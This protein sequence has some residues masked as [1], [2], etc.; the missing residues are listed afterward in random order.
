M[1][2]DTINRLKNKYGN[3]VGQILDYADEKE[4][5]LAKYRNIEEYQANL[6]KEYEALKEKLLVTCEALSKVRM[7]YAD[8]MAQQIKDV[9][10]DLNF[11]QV[12]F[13]IS[14]SKE[15]QPTLSGYDRVEFLISTNP[16]L[17]LRPIGQVASGGELSRIMLAVKSVLADVDKIETLV[18]DEIDTGVSGRT[19]QMVAEKLCVISR[20]HQVICITH[21]PQI[22]AMAD[23]HF[24]IV[25]EMEEDSTK[26]EM[27]MLYEDASVNELA[28]LLGG[29][30]ITDT[31]LQS[32]KEMKQMAAE[33]KRLQ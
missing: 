22:A 12:Q 6:K 13:E 9:L 7:N 23:T 4:A 18:F 11:L 14:L 19:A 10:I 20:K 8:K 25:K 1:R 29:A 3:S 17:P 5:E 15:E 21:L 33:K 27:K 32:A 16:G 30:K 26:T 2:L 31:V 24:Q 28:R